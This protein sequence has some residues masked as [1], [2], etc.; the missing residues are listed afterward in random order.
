MGAV[1]AFGQG[2]DKLWTAC[3]NGESRTEAIPECWG[4]Y[5]KSASRVW[6]PLPNL[7]YASMGFSRSETLVLSPITMLSIAAADE[8]I[9]QAHIRNFL[10]PDSAA[11]VGSAKTRHSRG[12]VFIGTGLTAAKTLFDNY[13]AH[14]LGSSR[15]FL[16]QLATAAPDDEILAEHVNSLQAHPRVNPLVIVQSMPNAVS[17]A[18]GI[19]FGLRGPNE[20]ACFACASGTIAIGKAFDAIRR[21]EIDFAFAGGV[22]HLSDRAGGVFMGFD[23]LQTLARPF[24]EIGS[25]NRPFDKVR[26]GFLFSEGGAALLLLE[27]DAFASARGAAACA[28]VVGFGQSSDASSVVSMSSTDNAIEEMYAK[29]LNS[30]AID[31]EQIGYI[32]AHGTSTEVNDAVEAQIIE[33]YFG[34]APKVNSTKSILGHTIGASGAFEAI[35]SIKSLMDQKVHGSRN[36]EN[37][38]SDLNFCSNTEPL[39]FEYALSQSFAFGGHNAGLIFRRVPQ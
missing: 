19:R 39:S 27:S 13:R 25:E 22:E 26:S 20:T 36:L 32:N 2:V 4:N 21:G 1:S 34:K 31:K 30:A 33:R 11:S 29:A 38:I 37:A 10:S 16:A 17:A 18:L 12:G 8:A 3:L 7:D 14:L 6:S 24:R 35:V 28:E 23:R 15:T 5:Y 9:V